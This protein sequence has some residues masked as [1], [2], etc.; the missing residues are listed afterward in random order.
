M[1]LKAW[2]LIILSLVCLGLSPATPAQAASWQEQMLNSLNS[3]RADQKLA[4]LTLCRPLTTASQK[5]ANVLARQNFL[6][7]EGKDGSTPGKRMQSAG[8]RWMNTQTGSMVAENI[9]GGQNSVSTVMKSWRNSTGHYK[10]M[11]EPKFT[12][13]GFGMAMNPNSKYK[14]Y[15]VQNFGFGATC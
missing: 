2:C 10:N 8:Y 3:I 14:K 11:V 1:K 12:H 9:A 5:Y 7:H 15:W 6:A 4:P 13:V